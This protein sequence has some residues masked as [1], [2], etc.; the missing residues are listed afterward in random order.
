[1]VEYWSDGFSENPARA[2]SRS[3][4]LVAFFHNQAID[5]VAVS[6]FSFET[7][8]KSKKP[9][10]DLEGE[11]VKFRKLRVTNL[12]GQVICMEPGNVLRE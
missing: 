10:F 3:I 8:N 5:P 6:P 4:L 2:S 11:L 1:M 9:I 7:F 12:T